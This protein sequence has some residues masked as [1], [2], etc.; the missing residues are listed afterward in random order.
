MLRYSFDIIAER[1]ACAA[2]GTLAVQ[3]EIAPYV[4]TYFFRSLSQFQ[5]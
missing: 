1:H 2:V 5:A 3:P 4:K